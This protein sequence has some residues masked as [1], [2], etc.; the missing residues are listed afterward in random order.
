MSDS[1]VDIGPP[2]HKS[3]VL[4]EFQEEFRSRKSSILKNP[5]G[6]SPPGSHRGSFQ[7]QSVLI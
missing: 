6:E 3:A 2:K 4:E 5:G 7:K 1:V